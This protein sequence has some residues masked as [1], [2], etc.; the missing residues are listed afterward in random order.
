[1]LSSSN[2]SSIPPISDFDASERI[3]NDLSK[4]R[5]DNIDTLIRRIIKNSNALLD[6]VDQTKG[7]FF[8]AKSYKDLVTW[9]K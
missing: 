3:I 2:W 4:F 8:F 1:M 7:T 5:S 9:A 6:S